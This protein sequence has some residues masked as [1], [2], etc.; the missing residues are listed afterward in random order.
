MVGLEEEY[1]ISGTQ[2]RK[3]YDIDALTIFLLSA[4]L[5]LINYYLL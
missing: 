5:G 1:E 2:T 3:I 4:V